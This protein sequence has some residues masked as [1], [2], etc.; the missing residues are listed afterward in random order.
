MAAS[1]HGTSSVR[2]AP[3]PSMINTRVVPGPQRTRP[4]A[5][6]PGRRAV[7]DSLAAAIGTQHAVDQQVRPAEDGLVPGDVV[8]GDDRRLG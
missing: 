6:I 3:T 2:D 5:T 8:G 4:L 7:R 1:S